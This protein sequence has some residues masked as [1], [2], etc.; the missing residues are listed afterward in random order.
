MGVADGQLRVMPGWEITFWGHTLALDNLIPPSV[1]VGLFL[2]M[3]VYPFVE[4]WV[5]GDGRAWHLLDRPRNRP[6]RTALG[7]SW[8][9][10][11]LVALI[12]AA[13]DIIAIRFHVSVEF[14]FSQATT[15]LVEAAVHTLR[16]AL[17]GD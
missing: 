17:R 16:T 4:A 13:N 15:A 1:G 2:A 5:T 7:V 9:S 8:I 6:V 11:Y 14:T 10:F 12:G 3:G